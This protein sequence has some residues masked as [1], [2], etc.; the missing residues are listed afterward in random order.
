MKLVCRFLGHNWRWFKFD[1][2]KPIRVCKRCNKVQYQKFHMGALIWV[3]PVE[4][5]RKGAE[6]NIEHYNE[7]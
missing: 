3:S 6:N 4:Y 5:T 1:F 2:T 7:K